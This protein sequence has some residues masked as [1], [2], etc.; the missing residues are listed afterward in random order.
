MT[1]KA[2]MALQTASWL[3]AEPQD[4]EQKI[5][6][7]VVGQLLQT[8]LYEEVIPF[9]IETHPNAPA[10]FIMQ[11]KSL[12]NE[13]V[14]YRCYG[15]QSTSFDLIR[16]DFNSLERIDQQANKT[17]GSLY[18]LIDELLYEVKQS[19]HFAPFINEIEQTFIKDVQSRKQD[20]QPTLPSVEL[21]PEALE[22]HFM[23]AHSY[24]PC[25]K[26]RIGFSLTENAQFGPEFAQPIQLIWLAVAKACSTFGISEQYISKPHLFSQHLS[27]QHSPDD[28]LREEAGASNWQAWRQQLTE[29][30]LNPDDFWF[31]PV[32]PW[33]WEHTIQSALAQELITED[34]VYLCGT[35]SQYTA[36]QSLRTLQNM[37]DVARPYVVF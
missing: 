14:E 13:S 8:L 21:S 3:T 5:E 10:L 36:Q 32:H 24:H 12:Q 2:S 29:N 25:Y 19:P 33:Q 1:N 18:Q 26:S 30:N 16:L 31:I 6:R 20:Y 11:G 34:I 27:S 37:T 17:T 22:Q 9:T 4:I 15:Y 28:F 23:D 7:R 35:Q